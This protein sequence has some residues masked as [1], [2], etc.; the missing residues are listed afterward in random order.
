M[1][2]SSKN[3]KSIIYNSEESRNVHENSG[4][5]QQKSLVIGNGFMLDKFYPDKADRL[6]LRKILNISETTLVFFMLLDGIKIKIMK[7]V[8]NP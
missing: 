8:S 3:P 1:R 2:F 7:H 6:N 5:D 4:Y